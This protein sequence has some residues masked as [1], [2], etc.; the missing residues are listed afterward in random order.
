MNRI[1]GRM[2]TRVPQPQLL[3]NRPASDACFSRTV[4]EA[5][6]APERATWPLNLIWADDNSFSVVRAIRWQ[7]EF[8]MAPCRLITP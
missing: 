5:R 1:A 3:E 6:T 4:T 7:G 8:R 2:R